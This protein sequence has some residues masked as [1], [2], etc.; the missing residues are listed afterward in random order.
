[1]KFCAL[2]LVNF[3]RNGQNKYMY[4]CSRNDRKQTDNTSALVCQPVANYSS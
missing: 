4:D 1:M 2:F 3:Y